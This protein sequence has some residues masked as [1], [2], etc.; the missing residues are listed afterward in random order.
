MKAKER[1]EV[2]PWMK[3]LKFPNGFTVGF[4]RTVNLN[5]GKLTCVKSHDYHIIMEW[6]LPNM[7]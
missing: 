3:N 2:M 4:R 1:K 7:L 6:L 5:T